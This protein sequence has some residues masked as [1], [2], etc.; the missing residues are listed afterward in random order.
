MPSLTYFLGKKENAKLTEK[1]KGLCHRC[2][3]DKYPKRHPKLLK[4]F[5]R[6]EKSAK[7]PTLINHIRKKRY[8]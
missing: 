4:D 5:Q 1:D 2:Y 3:L 6:I 8:E 7:K